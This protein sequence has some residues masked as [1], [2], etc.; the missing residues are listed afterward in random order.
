MYT[1]S[2][3]KFCLNSV[4]EKSDRCTIS[5]NVER[6]T[7]T[8]QLFSDCASLVFCLVQNP[9]IAYLTPTITESYSNQVRLELI[10]L[11]K[12]NF[13]LD[14]KKVCTFLYFLSKCIDL[15]VSLSF[16]PGQSNQPSMR[17]TQRENKQRV[18]I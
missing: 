11:K 4:S 3:S 12:S 8:R 14:I 18:Q 17:V 16:V 9:Q 15:L 6:E 1:F 13:H 7:S 10:R 5:K 2:V